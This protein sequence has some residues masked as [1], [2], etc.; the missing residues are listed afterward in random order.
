MTYEISQVSMVELQALANACSYVHKA[1]PTRS[2][3]IPSYPSAKAA[4][5]CAMYRLFLPSASPTC[6]S[7]YN[8]ASAL[9]RYYKCLIYAREGRISQG[10]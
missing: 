3:K 8:E 6:T 4:R 10:K 5:E 9:Q 1:R 2:L 7:A